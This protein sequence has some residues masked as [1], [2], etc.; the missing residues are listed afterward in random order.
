MNQ[1]KS[2]VVM[3]IDKNLLEINGKLTFG[4]GVLS[5]HIDNCVIPLNELVDRIWCHR[6]IQN[7]NNISRENISTC[8]LNS[9]SVTRMDTM[10]DFLQ[11]VT[12]VPNLPDKFEELS[13]LLTQT[14]YETIYPIILKHVVW[15]VKRR[16]FQLP[17]YCPIF[18]N[19]YGSAG[20]GK[21]E[22]LRAMFSIFPST[23]KSSVTNAAELFN[24]ERQTFRFVQNFV[25]VMDELTGLNRADLNKLKNM[26]DTLIVVYR[27]LG[28]NKT[29]M[30]HNNA[31]LIGTSNTR[32]ANTLKTD[33]DIRKWAEID[34]FGYPD[35]EIPTKMIT[36]MK[37]FD[38][39]SLW[40][41]VDENGPSPFHNPDTYS[42]FKNWTAKK[43]QHETGTT[44]FIENILNKY[45]GE[46]ISKLE[47]FDKQYLNQVIDFPLGW[48][49]FKEK[50]EKYGCKIIRKTSGMGIQF[51]KDQ[52]K[53]SFDTEVEETDY[54]SIC[55]L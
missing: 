54:E 29:A 40:K 7:Q 37:E 50:I 3:E 8:L 39:F 42:N 26:I 22:F 13:R 49:G 43:C 24:D 25:I 14:N 5:W 32:L 33:T 2:N 35:N 30:G 51:P 21:S 1:H 6:Q 16:L 38:W 9:E 44:I 19:I 4:N 10:K 15:T 41:S 28:F 31:Q 45:S 23:L 34:M 53:L 18:I 55:N 46:W 48:S 20:I 12:Y 36:P 47:L 11:S 27:M 52:K 17:D